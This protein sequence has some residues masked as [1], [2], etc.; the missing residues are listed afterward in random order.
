MYFILMYNDD[1]KE[2][3]DKRLFNKKNKIIKKKIKKPKIKKPKIEVSEELSDI[4]N[5]STP[6]K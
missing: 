4:S 5:E 3:M 1:I 2:Y 6:K